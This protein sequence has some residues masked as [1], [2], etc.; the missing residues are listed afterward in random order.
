MPSSVHVFQR[1]LQASGGG[2]LQRMPVDAAELKNYIDLS[3]DKTSADLTAARLLKEQQQMI[4]L[5]LTQ[6]AAC[7]T[8]FPPLE[9][10]DGKGIDASH[11]EHAA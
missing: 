11:P 9:W 7:L 8:S 3:S 5:S 4:A 6:S 1:T 10:R 2:D